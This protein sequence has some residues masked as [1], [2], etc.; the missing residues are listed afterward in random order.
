MVDNKFM[1]EQ[2]NDLQIIA[3]KQASQIERVVKDVT[4]IENTIEALHIRHD[5]FE[6]NL[7]QIKNDMLTEKKLT[8]VMESSFN[9]H[10]VKSLVF[11]IKALAA[12]VGASLTA[13]A[14]DFTDF[15]KQ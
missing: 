1:Q 14:V 7:N 2:L 5:T 4:I 12:I 6:H 8:T 13:W 15:F 10:I 9:H 11:T 3:A